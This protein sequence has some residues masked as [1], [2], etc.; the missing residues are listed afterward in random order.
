MTLGGARVPPAWEGDMTWKRVS[1][2]M[3]LGVAALFVLETTAWAR[4]R[5]SGIITK[6]YVIVDDTVLMGDVTCDVGSDPCFSFG[7]PGAQLLLNGF[8][9]TGKADPATGCGGALFAREWGIT[10]NGFSGVAVRG[11]G[12]IQR[13][14]NHGVNVSGST[15]ARVENLTAS[16]NCGSGI[17]VAANSFG[18]LV[19]DNTAVRNGASAPG[20]PCGGI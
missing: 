14:R 18:T 15:G 7:A 9:I 4:D 2:L 12:L 13:F 11:P 16:T 19:Q 17:F 5:V 10:T 3:V 6:T 1:G 8:S 20:S